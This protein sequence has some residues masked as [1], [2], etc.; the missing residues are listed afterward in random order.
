MP[1]IAEYLCKSFKIYDDKI[2]LLQ[3]RSPLILMPLVGGRGQSSNSR[4]PGSV[5]LAGV[6]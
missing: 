1:K 5:E 2:N 6:C 4:S 3:L